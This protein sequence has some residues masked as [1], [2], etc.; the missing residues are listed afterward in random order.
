MFNSSI[1][2][3]LSVLK[4]YALPLLE[5]I[6]NTHKE[7]SEARRLIVMLKYFEDVNE[8]YIPNNSLLREFIGGSL[9]E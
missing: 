5:E 4:K 9:F 8:K 7:Y 6:D 1:V 3:E 2:Y